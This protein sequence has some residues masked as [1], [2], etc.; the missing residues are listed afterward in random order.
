MYNCSKYCKSF[1]LKFSAILDY[2]KQG[3]WTPSW[4][5]IKIQK[6]C[7]GLPMPICLVGYKYFKNCV[8]GCLFVEFLY[9][10]SATEFIRVNRDIRLLDCQN[11]CAGGD[12]SFFCSMAISITIFKCQ[13]NLVRPKK[14]NTFFQSILQVSLRIL[15]E[16]SNLYFFEFGISPISYLPMAIGTSATV[17]PWPHRGLSTYKHI[18]TLLTA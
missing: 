7:G 10:F 9:K 15:M 13:P 3:L 4:R 2:F 17:N 16:D 14:C 11:F 6:P 1:A 18:S 5:S 8:M 12:D